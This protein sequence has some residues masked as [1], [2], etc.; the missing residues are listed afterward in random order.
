VGGP[1]PYSGL[2]QP[3]PQVQDTGPL[4]KLRVVAYQDITR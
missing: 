2:L 4:T 3:A 1:A